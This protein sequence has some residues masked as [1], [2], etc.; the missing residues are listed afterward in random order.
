MGRVEPFNRDIL[1]TSIMN[2]LQHRKTAVA[3]ATYLTEAIL[4]RVLA[5]KLP[6]FTTRQIASITSET[7][8]QFDVTAAAVYDA[9]HS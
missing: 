2:A 8:S 3:D 6:Q 4:S 1:F 5:L 9:K 7:L